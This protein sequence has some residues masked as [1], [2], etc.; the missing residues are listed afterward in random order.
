MLRRCHNFFNF[1][2]DEN[3]SCFQTGLAPQWATLAHTLSALVW[4]GQ[5]H[6]MLQVQRPVAH[7]D[8]VMVCPST[9]GFFKTKTILFIFNYNAK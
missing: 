5:S 8:R 6:G 7:Q 4:N 1:P 9:Q 3:V 2:T